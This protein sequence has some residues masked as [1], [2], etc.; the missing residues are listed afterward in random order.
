VEQKA[1][2]MMISTRAAS[3]TYVAMK[4]IDT[5]MGKS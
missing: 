1:K 3:K 2:A 5:R 4:W